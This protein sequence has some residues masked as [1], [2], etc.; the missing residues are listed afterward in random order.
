MLYLIAAVSDDD[1]IGVEGRLPWRLKRELKWFKM[2]THNGAVIM[3]RK[4]WDSL[5]KKPLPHRL[6]IVITRGPLQEWG[7][8]T[9]WTH[10]LKNAIHTAYTHTKRVYIIGGS[11]I[12][13]LALQNYKC[14][15]LITRVHCRV[16]PLKPSCT[17]RLPDKKRLVWRSREQ[18]E[19]SMTYHF[20]YYDI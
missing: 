6:N 13:K 11:E 18:T 10:S 3:G 9:I 2:N 14:K 19:D 4:T 8:D 20:E 17:L 12:F 1:V 7:S 15:L 16:N 5:T